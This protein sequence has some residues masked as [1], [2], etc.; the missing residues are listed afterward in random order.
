MRIAVISDIHGNESALQAVIEDIGQWHVDEII[1]LGDVATLGPAPC[2]AIQML[3]NLNCHC[4][5]GNHDA[6]MT[7]PEQIR[8]YTS[9]PL[10]VNAVAWC[11]NQLSTDDLAFIRTFKPCIELADASGTLL[12]F[13]G[14]PQNHTQDILSTTPAGD[15]DD[16]LEGN[17][18][19]VM[20]CGHT[21]IQML[22]QHKGMLILN[23]GSVG[24]P[25][26]EYVAGC[27]PTLLEHAEYAVIEMT[28][29]H[30]DI[31]LRRI[32]YDREAFKK[33]V[34]RCDD[35]IRKLLAR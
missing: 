33:A 10:V 31:K 2:N 16:M 8:S 13:H 3:R 7:H 29:A 30:T 26:K 5:L 35:P 34:E 18:A 22:R 9:D 19:D 28:P 32:S 24:L 25:F 20:A 4:I 17:S 6:F 27:K 1:C 15:L 12:C 11:R 21:H 14:S 23:P